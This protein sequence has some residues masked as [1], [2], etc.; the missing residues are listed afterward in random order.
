M[1]KVIL[2]HLSCDRCC[3]VRAAAELDA[4]LSSIAQTTHC[5]CSSYSCAASE[6]DPSG[7]GYKVGVALMRRLSSADTARGA[8]HDDKKYVHPPLSSAFYCLLLER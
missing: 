8:E 6:H 5:P 4:V 3:A 2:T 7:S 1:I